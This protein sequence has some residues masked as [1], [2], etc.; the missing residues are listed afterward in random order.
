MAATSVSLYRLG[1]STVID[2]GVP[3]TAIAGPVLGG[4]IVNPASPADQGLANAEVLYVDCSGAPAANHETATTVGI[5]PGGSFTLPANLQ[6][7]VSVNAASAGH[8]F[9]GFVVQVPTPF[10]PVPQSG[11]FPPTAP[12]TLIAT[13][14]AYLYE[15]Y[16]DD[17]ALQAFFQSYNAL[18]QGYVSWFTQVPL[19]VYTNP[20]I[21]GALLD[22]V[23]E[24]LY[25]FKRPALSSGRNR[26]V[27]PLNTFPYNS[28]ALNRRKLVGPNNVTVTTDDVFR[29][30]L[31]W[32]FY[33]GD[34]NVFN[35]EWLKRRLMRFLIGTD[36]AAP[37]VDQTY[38]ISVTYGPGVIA[39]KISA[40]TRSLL[41]GT[42]Y[43]RFGFNQVRRPLNGMV[44]QFNP[45]PNQLPFEPILKEAIDA[46]VLTF[47]F[48]YDV[49]IVI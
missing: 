2:S 8:R 15:Q 6:T 45:N 33:K 48:Q 34:G 19:P 35:V 25:G 37:N 17:D 32:N 47:P 18:V 23:A 44:T 20:A 5:Q 42:L 38:A 49:T 30:I 3:V 1:V 7:S 29:R 12:T 14:P 43:N 41:G 24:G 4:V 40:G 31:T 10:P 28:L 26:D 16:A 27:G 13:I 11:T 36:G 21:S 22:W 46:G 39:I 9:S